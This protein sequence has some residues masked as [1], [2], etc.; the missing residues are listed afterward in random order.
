VFYPDVWNEF[1]RRPRC[2]GAQRRDYPEWHKGRPRYYVWAVDAETAPVDARLRRERA[3]LD[4]RLVAPYTRHAHITVAACGF[5][6]DA[7]LH[8][9]DVSAAR[10]EAQARRLEALATPPFTVEV[11]GANSF[12]SAPFLEVADRDGAL[13]RLRAAVLDGGGE[14]RTTP[15][16]PHVTIG[17]YDGPHPTAAIAPR[18]GRRDDAAITL[19]V[20]RIGLYSYAAASLG[21]PLRL[22]RTIPFARRARR[23]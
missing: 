21:S 22:E 17:I 11:G 2:L 18:L 10:L 16:V 4:G 5:L 15:Y 3:A 7:A 23:A 19:N 13:A 1:V 9:D 12:A 14:Y 6:T 20:S 8:D